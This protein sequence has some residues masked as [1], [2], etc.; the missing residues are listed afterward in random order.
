ML[1]GVVTNATAGMLVEAGQNLSKEIEANNL[2]LD[3]QM[4]APQVGKLYADALTKV[5]KGDMEGFKGITAATA[6]SAG[7]PFLMSIFKDMDTI[8]ARLAD[9]HLDRVTATARASEAEKLQNA[10]ITAMND[11]QDKQIGA[12]NDRQD[13]MINIQREREDNLLFR[14]REDDW[15]GQV[16]KIDNEY[17]KEVQKI[18]E[19]NKGEAEMAK[20]D[21]SYKPNIQQI[22]PKPTYPAKPEPPV[23]GG[24]PLP[25]DASV[26][27]GFEP[28]AVLPSLPGATQVSQESAK[29]MGPQPIDPGSLPTTAGGKD[30]ATF[31][32]TTAETQEGEPQVV[33]PTQSPEIVKKAE[34]VNDSEPKNGV[35][36]RQV[37]NLVIEIPGYKEDAG[38]TKHSRT[39]KLANGTATVTGESQ[40]P[41]QREF[42]KAIETIQTDPAFGMFVSAHTWAGNKVRIKEEKDA[43]GKITGYLP[44]VVAKNGSEAPMKNYDPQGQ[45]M[46]TDHYVTKEVA[47]ALTNFEKMVN[48]DM[49]GKFSIYLALTKEQQSQK[50][51]IAMT[52]VWSGRNLD[53][54]NKDLAIAR[55]KPLTKEEVEEAK[56]KHESE[57]AASYERQMKSVDRGLIGKQY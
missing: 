5:A 20:L 22:P 48:G 35:A 30:L 21:P 7:N 16:A 57:A 41:P 13:K 9:S 36:T 53:N 14:Q 34:V 55:I 46:A 8:G 39:I 12:S 15:R 44:M 23:S 28:G 32:Q 47:E 2:R 4:K 37:G 24:L 3:A 49:K 51:N 26:S 31:G 6:A 45:E 17:A 33:V 1:G 25:D 54:A 18:Q 11:R 10:R 50:R 52:Q 29:P 43:K 56:K 40:T 38:K 42:A 19:A 27:A